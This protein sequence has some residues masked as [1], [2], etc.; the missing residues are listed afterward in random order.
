MHDRQE[1]RRVIDDWVLSRDSGDWDRLAGLWAPDGYMVTTWSQSSAAEFV[2]RSRKAFDD[3]LKVLHSLGGTSIDLAGD[4]AVAQ[5]R[6]QILQRAPVEGVLADVTCQGRFWDAFERRDGRWLLVFRQPAYELD[7][8]RPVDPSARLHLDA[9]RL[10]SYPEGYRHL[11]YL[12]SGLG[13]DVG[14]HLPGTRGPEIQDL[15]ARG[16]RWLAGESTTGLHENE[17]AAG[18]A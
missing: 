9:E 18:Q 6:M 14:R 15:Q 16:R 7:Q 12:Q 3:G 17:M 13:F 8:I 2:A 5:T 1:I 10:A 11:A 4:R